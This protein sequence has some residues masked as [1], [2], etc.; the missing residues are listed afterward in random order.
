MPRYFFDTHDGARFTRDDKGKDLKD[1]AAA[2]AEAKKAL[3]DIVKDEMPDEAR[4]AF[5]VIVKDEAVR[6]ILRVT[7]S[8]NVEIPSKAQPQPH[9]RG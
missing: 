2:K 7:L 5:V 1:L 4:R 6:P 8:L 9:D 3:P